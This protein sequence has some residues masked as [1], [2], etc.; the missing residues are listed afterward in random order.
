MYGGTHGSTAGNVTGLLRHVIERSDG[1][2]ASVR[3]ML[4]GS[5]YGADPTARHARRVLA[6]T[7]NLNPRANYLAFDPRN[8]MIKA[9]HEPERRP[10]DISLAQRDADLVTVTKAEM[11]R[12]GSVTVRMTCYDGTTQIQL[13]SRTDGAW[14]AVV[15]QNGEPR[16]YELTGAAFDQFRLSRIRG[17]EDLVRMLPQIG[18][19]TLAYDE[20]KMHTRLLDREHDLERL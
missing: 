11:G 5:T 16:N 20:Q 9:M 17:D 19:M 13:R 1:T 8:G 6:H 14:E 3:E 15:L 7:T 10:L 4:E 18:A 12:D 2:I